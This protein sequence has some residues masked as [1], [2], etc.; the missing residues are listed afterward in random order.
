MIL[1]K[2]VRGFNDYRPAQDAHK[3]VINRGKQILFNALADMI[4]NTNKPTTLN[5]TSS[6]IFF[7]LLSME[8]LPATQMSGLYFNLTIQLFN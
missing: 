8:I 4:N 5:D 1:T 2:L 7:L 6:L 3:S